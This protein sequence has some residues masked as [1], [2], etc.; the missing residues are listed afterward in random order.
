MFVCVC[1]CSGMCL[2]VY[3]WYVVCAC[4]HV[5][6]LNRWYVVCAC[7]HV[8]GLGMVILCLMSICMKV[9]VFLQWCLGVVVL[10]CVG[11]LASW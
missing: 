4:A 6:G 5:R 1:L 7:A 3:R 2:T 9:H 10:F 8:R 11:V